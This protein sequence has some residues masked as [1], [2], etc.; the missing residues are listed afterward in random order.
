MKPQLHLTSSKRRLSFP[1][2]RVRPIGNGN[3]WR[4]LGRLGFGGDGRARNPG[5]APDGPR[6]L[7]TCREIAICGSTGH[8][9][10]VE[11]CRPRGLAVSGPAVDANEAAWLLEEGARRAWRTRSIWD[12]LTAPAQSAWA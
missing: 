5:I 9:G 4:R 10:L 11:R 7:D 3:Q 12:G 1:S 8:V 2:G 6:I